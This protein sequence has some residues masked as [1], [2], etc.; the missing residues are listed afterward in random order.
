MNLRLMLVAVLMTVSGAVYAAKG[1]QVTGPVT[2]LTDSKIVVTKGTEKFE[3]ARNPQTK[4]TGGELKVGDRVTVY[5]DMT[6]TDVEVKTDKKM[7][8]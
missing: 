4:V 5:Y 3:V 8:K 6:A 1:Y 2:E 7:K